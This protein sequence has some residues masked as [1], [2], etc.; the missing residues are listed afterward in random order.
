MNL[1]VISAACIV[2]VNRAP[3]IALSNYENINLTLLIPFHKKDFDSYNFKAENESKTFNI[4]LSEIKGSHPRLERLTDLQNIIERV[5]PDSILLEFDVATLMTFQAIKFSRKFN[6]K[7][8]FVALENFNRSFILESLVSALKFDFKQ[9]LGALLTYFL[10][11]F[12]RKSINKTYCVSKDGMEAM[13]YLGFSEDQIVKIPLGIDTTLFYPYAESKILTLRNKLNLNKITIAYFGRIIPEKGI[14]HLLLA[15]SQIKN[16]EWQLLVDN[17]SHYKSDYFLT[18]KKIVEDYQLQDRII[19]FD[20]EHNEMPDYINCADIV[21]LPSIVKNK[22]KEQYGRVVA[23]AICCGKITLVS[24]SGA[25]PE[26]IGDLGHVFQNT[27]ISEL[28]EKLKYLIIS[29]ESIKKENYLKIV[30]R[31]V[32]ILSANKQAEI[33][34]NTL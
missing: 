16:L 34:Y 26:L 21:V 24:D 10:L 30:N 15:L 12:N 32:E 7:I 11:S 9:S 33:I 5:K 14:D 3:F 28:V 13:K 27:N 17:F 1:L 19:Y 18:L 4:I 23:E 8:S 25:L 29:H 22:F 31:G 6:S 2:D 20:A